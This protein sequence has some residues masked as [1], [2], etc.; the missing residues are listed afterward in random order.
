MIQP[1][2]NALVQVK[3]PENAAV[4]RTSAL[5]NPTVQI[6]K[7]HNDIIFRAVVD[8][9]GNYVAAC[10]GDR[11][12]SIWNVYGDCENELMVKSNLAAVLDIAWNVTQDSLIT[13]SADKSVAILD[14]STGEWEQSF[15]GHK[16][17]VNSVFPLLR[18]PNQIASASDDGTAKIWDTRTDQCIRSLNMTYPL[19]SV[20][21]LEDGVTLLAGGLD[22]CIHM[23][24]VRNLVKMETLKG[25]KDSITSLALSKDSRFVVS[26][27][28]DHTLKLWDVK[29]FSEGDRCIRTFTGHIH[30]PEKLMLRCSISDDMQYILSGSSD[31]CAHIWSLSSGKH[32]LKLP[33]HHGPVTS[34]MMHPK[35]PIV[36]S[37]SAD[38][39]IIL[40]ELS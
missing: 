32:L 35:E 23:W 21:V 12:I 31:N 5:A 10:S 7:A 30:G 20:V 3:Q 37:S 9:D 28:M 18:T 17:Q 26:N 34:A 25:H 19:T 29:P 33:G 24:D 40:G 8:L 22:N 1:P 6:K 15:F 4:N 2:N 16:A 36:V 11:H 39:S 27:A 13:A 38:R 14:T